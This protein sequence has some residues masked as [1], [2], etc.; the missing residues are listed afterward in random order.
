MP[1]TDRG[2]RLQTGQIGR[3]RLETEQAD[4]RADGAAAD[5]N[6]AATGGTDRVDLFGQAVDPLVVERAIVV[7]EDAGADFHND[8]V[9]GSGKLLAEFDV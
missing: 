3:P 1:L 9:G 5:E 4:P 2:D 8:R 6:H 7:R